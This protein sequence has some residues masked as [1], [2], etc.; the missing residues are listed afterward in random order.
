[1][2]PSEM[3]GPSACMGEAL[4]AMLLQA[5]KLRSAA[6]HKQAVEVLAAWRREVQQKQAAWLAAQEL[7]LK[8]CRVRAAAVFVALRQLVCLSAEAEK[9]ALV[10][11]C[12]RQARMQRALCLQGER[13]QLLVVL[14]LYVHEVDLEILWLLAAL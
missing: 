8:A 14:G 13:R 1:M 10:L 2:L 3:R 6:Q 12:R 11:N 5:D 4:K 7:R 9:G